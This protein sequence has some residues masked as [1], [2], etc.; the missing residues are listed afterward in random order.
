MKHCWSVLMSI[1]IILELAAMKYK[2]HRNR[3][4]DPKHRIRWN[5][6]ICTFLSLMGGMQSLTSHSLQ[7]SNR[8]SP[9]K[10]FTSNLASILDNIK[11][12]LYFNNPKVTSYFSQFHIIE[13]GM[14]L[15]FIKSHTIIGSILP[16]LVIY[17]T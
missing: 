10:G 2:R 6:N 3:D 15:Q 7:V 11:A 13:I 8:D 4:R 5:S 17:W 12:I 16:F 9:V 14:N 1:C